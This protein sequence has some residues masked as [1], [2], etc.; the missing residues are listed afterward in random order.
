MEDQVLLVVDL[1][2]VASVFAEQDPVT[3]LHV[4]RDTMAFFHLAG[5]D[6]DYFA[7]VG[8]FFSRIGDNDSALRGFFLLQSAYQ[9]TVMQGSYIHGHFSLNL[10][11]IYSR[12]SAWNSLVAPA[13]S[14]RV[15]TLQ[16]LQSRQG[17]FIGFLL[18]A[19]GFLLWALLL[20]QLYG[21]GNSLIGCGI[22]LQG[23]HDKRK[24]IH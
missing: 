18:L 6:G 21:F 11:S 7:L 15:K 16:I 13:P 23:I 17:K 8:L 4:E 1:D 14:L 5:T 19:I 12:N 3:D 2:V 22:G 9:D 20:F 24:A 10:H